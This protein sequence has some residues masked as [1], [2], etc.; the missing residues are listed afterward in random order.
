MRLQLRR[1]RVSAVI[2]AVG[3]ALAVACAVVL[4]SQLSGGSPLGDKTTL[5][6]AVDSAKSVVPGKNEVRWAGVVVGRITD[7][8]LD[9]DHA[10]LTAKID[11]EL[12]RPL[13]RD[14][15]LRLRPQTA[16]ND[17]YLDVV[18]S[19][20][21]SSGRLRAGDVLDAGRTK[22]TVDVAEVLN[23]FSVSVRDR[24]QQALDELSV[25]LSDGG[26]QLRSSFVQL[27][28]FVQAAH[29]IGAVIERRDR[30][31]RRLV[32][33]V[34]LTTD[35]L[36][37]RDRSIT[38]LV[39]SAGATFDTLGERRAE[40][41]STLRELPPTLSLMQASFGRLRGT[42]AEARPAL[43]A[44]R[45]AAR[46]LPSGLGSLRS[47]V[48]RLDPALTALRPAVRAL[49]PFARDLSPTAGALSTAFERLEP[50]LPR[51]DRIT[52]KVSSCEREIQKFFA[53]TMSVFKFGNKSNLTTSPRGAFISGASEVGSGADPNLV[54]VRSCADARPTP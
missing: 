22:T 4:L 18:R 32:R 28:P 48:G 3:G 17:M 47:L 51:L 9:G 38:R 21:P 41:D 26:A 16:L 12:A 36:G 7:A 52:A 31:T 49:S 23:V 8:D 29:R 33:S 24:F 54:P 53:W 40:L 15:R 46:A 11:S 19:G 37:R 43:Q 20:N 34:R 44:L 2:V 45:P 14:A 1:A 25:G 42:L 50:Q 39:E 6:V 27:V 30:V 13:Y 35:E 10:V 5:R